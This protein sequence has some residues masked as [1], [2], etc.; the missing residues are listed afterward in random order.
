[1]KTL[2]KLKI[3]FY[4]QLLKIKAILEKDFDFIYEDK[5]SFKR[6]VHQSE[7]NPNWWFNFKWWKERYPEGTV[8]MTNPIY[9]NKKENKKEN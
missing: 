9:E 1:M 6:F 3:W 4:R 7:T 5:D 2:R 8:I